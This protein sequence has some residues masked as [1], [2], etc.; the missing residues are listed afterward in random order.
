ME[1]RPNPTYKQIQINKSYII[2]IDDIF[3]KLKV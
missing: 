2:L 1:M 3:T